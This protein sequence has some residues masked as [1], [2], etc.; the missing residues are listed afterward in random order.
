MKIGIIPYQKED[1][2]IDKDKQRPSFLEYQETYKGF[3]KPIDT[4][5]NK[6]HF[7][8]TPCAP[9][10]QFTELGYCNTEYPFEKPGFNTMDRSDGLSMINKGNDTVGVIQSMGWRS[11]RCDVC[12]KEGVSYWEVIVLKGGAVAVS[13]DEDGDS[14]VKTKDAIDNSPH[15]RF[16]I[17]RREMSLEAPVGFDAYGYGIRDQALESVHEGKLN[18]K[19]R[20]KTQ[21]KEGDRIGF[22]LT[23][24]DTQEQIE[25]AREYTMRRL[26]ALLQSGSKGIS[27]SDMT[28][29]NDQS[30]SSGPHRKK[31]KHW[32][33]SQK[34]FQEA[35]LRD[36]DYTNIVRDQ[37]AIRY[38]GQL[39][40]EG[41]DYVKTTKPEYY[42]S[43]HRERQDYYNLKG[44][45][46]KLYLNGEYLG[47][48]FENLNP[49]LPPFSEL[50]YNEKFY[51]NYWK[52]GG[53]RLAEDHSLDRYNDST[54]VTKNEKLT[55]T[56]NSGGIMN[57]LTDV[58]GVQLL[59]NK[60][61]NNN[62]LGY[63]PTVSCFNGGEAKIITVGSELKY[64]EQVKEQEGIDCKIN[65]LD[66]LF[67]EQIADDIIWDIVDELEE[68]CKK[69][70]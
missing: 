41:T 48:S 50:Q 69:G 37:I 35:L 7:I 68:E 16:G 9:I 11:G 26:D 22:V 46:L 49:F 14:E 21:L 67:N 36:I 51:Y 42:S 57:N 31:L 29:E 59:R 60:Y 2:E 58:K 15:L 65:T 25:Q 47:K 52:N 44:S 17:S 61:V 18:Q 32:K 34:E 13:N 53:A 3:S 39:L 4:P 38:K 55:E 33:P 43:D 30:L 24:P 19:I 63:Y 40:F 70:K 8:Y 62:R 66:K 6:R 10:S 20:T 64:L 5:L 54:H 23:L 28:S 56:D 45:S 1:F 12:I 27:N